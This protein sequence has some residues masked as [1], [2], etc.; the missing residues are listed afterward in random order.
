MRADVSWQSRVFFTPFND[1]VET[2]EPHA[3]A[4]LRA[5]WE[6][7]HRGWEL[8]VF[9]RNLGNR[10]YVTGTF[11]VPI[12]AIGGRPGEPRQWGTQITLR[13]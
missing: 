6:P 13:R 1:R 12:T 8:A 11:A 2:Q 4:H 7:R 10:P 9:V 3:I 5:A